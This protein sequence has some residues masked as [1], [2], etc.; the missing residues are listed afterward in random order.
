MDR[1]SLPAVERHSLPA[2]DGNSL[3]AVDRESLPAVGRYSVHAVDRHSLPA[4]ARH[5]KNVT[6][7]IL[8]TAQHR[9][10]L[11]HVAAPSST[12]CERLPTPPG[13][14]SVFRVCA[15]TEP[16]GTGFGDVYVERSGETR[17][18]QMLNHTHTHTEK[19]KTRHPTLASKPL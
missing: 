5:K 7:S 11:T 10:V 8:N 1:H 3:P 12:N 19:L 9:H 18:K 2:V 4:V 16:A 17:T 14:E 15:C 6:F 13:R